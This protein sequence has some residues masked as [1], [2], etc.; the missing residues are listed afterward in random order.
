M[1]NEAV[2]TGIWVGDREIKRTEYRD[3][4]AS[5]LFFWTPVRIG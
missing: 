4:F 5:I 3:L 1:W 2:F